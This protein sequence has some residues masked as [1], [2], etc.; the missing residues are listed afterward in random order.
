MFVMFTPVPKMVDRAYVQCLLAPC[1]GSW[2]ALRPRKSQ[3]EPI[4]VGFLYH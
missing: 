1:C 2:G 3:I 4:R